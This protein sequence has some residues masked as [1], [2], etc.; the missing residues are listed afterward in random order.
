M[1][2]ESRDPGPWYDAEDCGCE[3]TKAGIESE[4]EWIEEFGY[5]MCSGCGAAQ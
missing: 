1:E 2:D 3:C 4:W 5:Y